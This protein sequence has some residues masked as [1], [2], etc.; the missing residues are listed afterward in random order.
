VTQGRS[1]PYPQDRLITGFPSLLDHY[2]VVVD[3]YHLTHSFPSDLDILLQWGNQGPAVLLMSDAGGI[4]PGMSNVNLTFDDDAAAF[5]PTSTPVSGVYRPTDIN[6]GFADNFPDPCPP[7]CI[8]SQPTPPF[9]TSLSAFKGLSSAAFWL[10]WIMDDAVGDTGSLQAW[11]LRFIPNPPPGEVQNIL[12]GN[13]ST[14]TWDAAV[15]ATSY[16]LYR[17]DPSQLSALTGSSIDSCPRA[18]TLTQQVA[19]LSEVPALGSWYWYLVRGHNAEGDGPAGFS[20]IA[21][22]SPAR[23]HDSSGVACP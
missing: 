21:S 8:A 13:A 3:L 2:K 16:N 12:W 10:L 7:S 23:I 6:D 20:W 9:S 18:T 11:C 19:G 5:V 15:S 14:L 22:Q 4:G 17:G 1:F